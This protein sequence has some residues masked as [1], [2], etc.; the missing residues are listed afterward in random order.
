[1]QQ[2]LLL[3]VCGTH[4]DANRP[5]EQLVGYWKICR[6]D[7]WKLYVVRLTVFRYYILSKPFR[8]TLSALTFDEHEFDAEMKGRQQPDRWN[9]ALVVIS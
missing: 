1:M 8:I 3:R 2:K 7:K 5:T 4:A 9:K 6:F